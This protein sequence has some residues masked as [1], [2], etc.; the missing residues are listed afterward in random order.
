MTKPIINII[1]VSMRSYLALWVKLEI[2]GQIIQYNLS[3]GG[4]ICHLQSTEPKLLF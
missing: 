2:N 1:A 4:K 3:T